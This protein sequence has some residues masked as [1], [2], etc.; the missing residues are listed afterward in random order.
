MSDLAEPFIYDAIEERIAWQ[1]IAIKSGNEWGSAV[2]V[3]FLGK[4]LIITAGHVIEN[5]KKDVQK[6][7]GVTI[8]A[9][10]L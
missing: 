2:A 7:G 5:I 8:S 4:F 9:M 6:I 1:T 3:K 10:L